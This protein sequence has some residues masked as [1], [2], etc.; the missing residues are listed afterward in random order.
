M[1]TIRFPDSGSGKYFQFSGMRE[2]DF[3]HKIT[4]RELISRKINF[5]VPKNKNK[6][7]FLAQLIKKRF[8]IY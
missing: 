1:H 7:L 6:P 4:P 5:R 2:I 3:P 8:N